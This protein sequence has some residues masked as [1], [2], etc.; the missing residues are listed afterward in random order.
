MCSVSIAKIFKMRTI[1]IALLCLIVVTVTDAGESDSNNNLQLILSMFLFYLALGVSMIIVYVVK[2]IVFPDEDPE[3]VQTSLV[4]S[5]VKTYIH[6]Y[7]VLFRIGCASDNFDFKRTT[8]DV[9]LFGPEREQIG[10]MIR[11]P[12]AKLTDPVD[13]YLK[14][15]MGR[16]TTMPQIEAIGIRH[17]GRA[18]A[19]IY[20]FWLRVF[21]VDE[22]TGAEKELQLMKIFEY[23]HHYN[24][25]ILY[26][27]DREAKYPPIPT[28]RLE[29]WEILV[30]VFWITGLI[31]FLTFV[32]MTYL[33]GEDTRTEKGL[34]YVS[35][36][37]TVLATII[38]LIGLIFYILLYKYK[39][40]EYLYKDK[41]QKTKDSTKWDKISYV[42][43][44]IVVG[45]AL[46]LITANLAIAWT[47]KTWPSKE[48]CWFA[49]TLISMALV[50]GLWFV[51]TYLMP[52]KKWKITEES[53]KSKSYESY[54][55]MTISKTLK[56]DNTTEVV[57]HPQPSN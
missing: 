39:L 21:E 8:I 41:C 53:T 26:E 7:T 17:S 10:A 35:G 11:F 45:L 19:K 3:E 32:T 33:I 1:C 14:I 49:S 16:I 20:L 37:S 47:K 56:N 50:F 5:S 18:D 57:S 34:V 24:K 43:N 30:V 44:G 27:S 2:A 9:E 36:I 15:N 31:S 22:K 23:V 46:A 12:C 42:C 52:G 4:M 13:S 28:P 38:A 48:W 40:K 54:K 55:S 25:I 51:A 6:Q 29:V